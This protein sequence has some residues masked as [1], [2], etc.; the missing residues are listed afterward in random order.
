MKEEVQ[1]S[2]DYIAAGHSF[3]LAQAVYDR[4][5]ALG[6]SQTALAGRAGMTQPQISAIEGGDATPTLPLLTRLA[7]ALEATLSIDLDG[8]D[9]SFTFTAHDSTRPDDGTANDR[10]SSAA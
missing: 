5:T 1:E 8:D 7:K 9:S 3:A 2:P 10:S 6:L 4:R